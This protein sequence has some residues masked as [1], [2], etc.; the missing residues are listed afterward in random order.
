MVENVHFGGQRIFKCENDCPYALVKQELITRHEVVREL[1]C[2]SVGTLKS[3]VEEQQKSV[4]SKVLA[5][6]DNTFKTSKGWS[7]EMSRLIDMKVPTYLEVQE[8]NAINTWGG[9]FT[10]DHIEIAGVGSVAHVAVDKK[11]FLI[12]KRGAASKFLTKQ[13]RCAK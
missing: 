9:W 4:A 10:E 3:W 1:P 11:L 12:E 5:C 6:C 7:M 13:T 2:K 8:Q